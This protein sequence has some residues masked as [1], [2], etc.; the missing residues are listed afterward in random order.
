MPQKS[1]ERIHQ[2]GGYGETAVCSNKSVDDDATLVSLKHT[3]LDGLLGKVRL[4]FCSQ[5]CIA[6]WLNLLLFLQGRSTHYT[7]Y[8]QIKENSSR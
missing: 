6:W 2:L 5:Y 3:M 4:L 7:R 8:S 1:I